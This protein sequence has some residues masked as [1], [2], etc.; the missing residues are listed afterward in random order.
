[1]PAGDELYGVSYDGVVYAVDASTGAHVRNLTA[2]RFDSFSRPNS[3]TVS[4]D[5]EVLAVGAGSYVYTWKTAD[6]SEHAPRWYAGSTVIQLRWS[7][8]DVLATSLYGDNGIKLWPTGIEPASAILQRSSPA[9]QASPE[10][11]WH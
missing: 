2:T 6:G 9:Y 7:L 11:A 5:G 3:V 10:I 8:A 1:H 4:P